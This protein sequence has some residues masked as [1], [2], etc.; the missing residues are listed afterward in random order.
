MVKIEIDPHSDAGPLALWRQSI[1]HGGINAQ[2]LPENV[3][4]GTAK[5]RPR[6][7]RI[8]IQE[9]F[10][11]YPSHGRCDWRKL[12]PYMDALAGTGANVVAAITIKPPILFPH[13]DHTL[14]QPADMGEW[15]ALIRQLVLRYSVEKQIVTHWEIGNEPD[16]GEAGGS[17]YLMTD[18]QV[19]HAY[20]AATVKPITEVFPQGVIGGPAAANLLDEPLPGFIEL[21]RQNGT[22]LD[23]LSWHLYHNDPGRHA[24]QVS[25][26][27]RLCAGLDYPVDLF[28]TEWAKL[29]A[30]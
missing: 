22:Q 26:A 14:W 10:N 5:L 11:V 7:I 12:D 4:L 17:P 15:Q 30:A 25:V 9:F 3:I 28:V 18:P 19:Y 27:K 8:F 20:Y 23:F 24:Y 2:P 16:I 13:I 29:P 1:G 21:C 6:W